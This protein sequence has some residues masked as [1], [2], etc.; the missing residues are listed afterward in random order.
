MIL[1]ACTRTLRWQY[2]Q[3]REGPV[4]GRA[5][6]K[7]QVRGAVRSHEQ[8]TVVTAGRARAIV[9]G[10]GAK[11]AIGRIRDAMAESVDE[12]TPLKKKL[13][14]FGAFLSK[15]QG[16]TTRLSCSIIL[17]SCMLCNCTAAFCG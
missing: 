6:G 7:T 8:G 15:V 10:S 17:L 5:H 4:Q 9:V 11:T 16:H 2:C 12:M 13:D 14:D 3:Y 1:S